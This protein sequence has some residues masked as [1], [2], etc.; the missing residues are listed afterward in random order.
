MTTRSTVKNSHIEHDLVFIF[1]NS[2][3]NDLK[4]ILI[5]PLLHFRHKDIL[6]KYYNSLLL[7][8]KIHFNT[9]KLYFKENSKTR[10]PRENTLR[11]IK[12]FCI[13]CN[14]KDE[15]L[16]QEF[17]KFIVYSKKD[18]S[19]RQQAGRVLSD[20]LL[21]YIASNKTDISNSLKKIPKVIL[22]KIVD[23]IQKKE[24]QNKKIV[25]DE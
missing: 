10:F 13:N 1:K 5:N 17:D 4:S 15:L 9:F 21:D 8:E 19:I 16:V 14:F 7:E 20:D 25:E 6:Q 12:N 24:I 3:I 2:R 18:H 23:S 22:D 11:I